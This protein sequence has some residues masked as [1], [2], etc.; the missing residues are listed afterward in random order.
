MKS[1]KIIIALLLVLC[2]TLAIAACGTTTDEETETTTTTATA[3]TP[4]T[5]DDSTG[6]D[7]TGDDSTGDDTTGD[8]TT[9]DDTSDADI[10]AGYYLNRE[11]FAVDV[12]KATLEGLNP[13]GAGES[14]AQ[15]FDGD[16]VN[17]KLGGPSSG[18]VTITFQTYA[19]VT[20]NSYVIFTG[21]DS[22][23]WTGRNPAGWVL[24]GSTD[25]ENYTVISTVEIAELE[26]LNATP[27]EYDIDSPAAYQYY[28][29]EFTKSG[30]LQLN[31]LQLLG[32]EVLT[33]AGI[34]SVA[35]S[36]YTLVENRGRNHTSFNNVILGKTDGAFTV[37]ADIVVG[38]SGDTFAADAGFLIAVED[39][40]EDGM[41]QE[42]GDYYYLVEIQ[43]GG[44][45]AIE[46]NDGTWRGWSSFGE[47][48][49]GVATGETITLTV[50][51]DGNG[52]FTVKAGSFEGEWTD[53]DPLTGGTFVT[54]ATK[55][56]AGNVYE[57][58]SFTLVEA[59]E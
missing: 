43:T 47:N 36:T 53:P 25:G 50:T 1:A 39:V 44:N 20:A 16:T 56:T 5:G 24:Y 27:Y 26:D 49:T 37:S 13:W 55:Q 34:W 7:S 10:V 6:D 33:D 8:D 35:G 57:N 22:A 4:S 2:L 23:Q 28:K 58:V 42:N 3:T 21:N 52:G 51:Y 9:G 32:E 17:T 40:N 12:E 30:D 18:T 45:V 54:L 38:S 29:I 14:L 15:F 41:F 19:P 48:P 11:V 59:D 46:R 31:E